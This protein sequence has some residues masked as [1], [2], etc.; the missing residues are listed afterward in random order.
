MMSADPELVFP[1]E[2]GL[3][4]ETFSA[5]NTY[6]VCGQKIT[7]LQNYCA[8]LGVSASVWDSALH[9][10]RFLE[11]ECVDL[12]GK[13]II[14]LGAGTGLVGIAT[15]RLGAHVTLTD[16][17]MAL[18]QMERNVA[19]NAPSTGWPSGAPAVLRLAWGRDHTLFSSSWDFVLG[20]DIVYLPESF[21]P[22]L[23]TLAHL[24]KDGAVVYLASPMRSELGAQDFYSRLLPQSFSV[25]LVRRDPNTNISVYKATLR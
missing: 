15:A 25:E 24:S 5:Q 23:D 7:I 3:F 14:E 6:R 11:E 4:E 18:P 16:V 9:L 8:N 22:L 10:C 19:C 21:P 17:P 1:A 2:D 12:R 20:S 13:R